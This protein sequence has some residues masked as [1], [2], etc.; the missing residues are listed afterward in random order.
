VKV[1]VVENDEFI[2]VEAPL[3]IIENQAIE[4]VSKWFKR[5]ERERVS[6]KL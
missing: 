2:S 3:A 1:E 4:A 6:A 5:H